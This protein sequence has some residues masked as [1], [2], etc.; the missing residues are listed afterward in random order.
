MDH[1]GHNMGNMDDGSQLMSMG[2][3]D[4]M[5]NMTGS[6]NCSMDMGMGM[7]MG[8]MNM[9]FYFGQSATILFKPWETSSPGGMVAS[10]VGIFLLAM[11]YEGLKYYREFLFRRQYASTRYG[12][13]N[14][15][16]REDNK[17]V[18]PDGQYTL[19]NVICSG[20]HLLQ[21][22]LHMLQ[23][24]LSYFL[25]LVFMTYNGWLC[26]SVIL[27]A[28]VGFFLFGWKKA[29]VVDVTEHCH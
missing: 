8:G 17:V 13:V 26:I 21:T 15:Q 10:C 3:N 28:G 29:M 4:T 5:G 16:P 22:F 12:T 6:G 11:V 20:H 9:Y 23:V 19:R 2:N 27:G 18:M 1:S 14:N 24:T 25:M 7:D